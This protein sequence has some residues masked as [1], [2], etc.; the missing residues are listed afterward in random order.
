MSAN[1]AKWAARILT[2][3]VIAAFA[4]SGIFKASQ[5]PMVV[6]GFARIG[7]PQWAILPL[8]ILE[9]ACLAVYLIPRTVVLGTLLLT[10]YL[11]GATLANLIA[12]TDV[13]HV[14]VVGL[15]VWAGAWF[16]VAELRALIPFRG[17]QARTAHTT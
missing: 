7:I 14:V 16:R 5:A 17:A 13:I 2:V 6:D 4:P 8:G 15:L 1:R 3:L 12:R 9:L 10:G 11:G